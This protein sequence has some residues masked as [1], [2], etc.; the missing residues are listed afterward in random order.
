M[1]KNNAFVNEEQI[2]TALEK[3]DISSE[4]IKD[5]LAKAREC[6]GISIEEAACLL[7]LTDKDL[8]NELYETAGYIKEQ[9]YGKRIV[10]FAPMYVSNICANNCLYCAFRTGNKELKRICQSPEEIENETTNFFIYTLC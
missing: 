2:F 7:Q 5:I 9:I 3:T 8:L 1:E 6:K 4:H 10:F